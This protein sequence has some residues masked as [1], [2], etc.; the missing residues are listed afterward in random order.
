MQASFE[1]DWR[2]KLQHLQSENLLAKNDYLGRISKMCAE[3]LLI[4]LKKERRH[5]QKKLE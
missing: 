4:D 2:Q 5:V 3:K 1:D